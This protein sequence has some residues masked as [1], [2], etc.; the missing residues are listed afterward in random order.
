MWRA[1]LPTRLMHS[2]F[3]LGCVYLLQSPYGLAAASAA[4][5]SKIARHYN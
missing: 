5:H 2:M 4:M 3:G 1:M